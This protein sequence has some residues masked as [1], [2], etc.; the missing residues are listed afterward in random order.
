M[1]AAER[2]PGGDLLGR[3]PGRAGVEHNVRAGAAGLTLMTLLNTPPHRGTLAA[4][5]S[6]KCCVSGLCGTR[7]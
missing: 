3:L 6:W 1:W 4:R 7:R 5:E 2:G